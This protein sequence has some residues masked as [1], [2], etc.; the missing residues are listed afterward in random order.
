MSYTVGPFPPGSTRA[1]ILKICR[2]WDWNAKPVQPKARSADGKGVLWQ[3]LAATAPDSEVY[4]LDHG[5]V[6]VTLDPPKKQQGP[7]QPKDLQAS[8]KT[9]AAL[10]T[11]ATA[12]NPDEDPWAHY[13]PWTTPPK[14]AKTNARPSA[15]KMDLE[16]LEQRLDQKLLS[17]QTRT[18]GDTTMTVEDERIN[19]LELRMQ[20]L[21]NNVQQHHQAY[22]TQHNEVQHQL[23]QVQTQ[24]A[25][26]GAT[27]NHLLDQRFTQQLT[28]IERIMAKRPKTNE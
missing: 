10:S 3:L 25:E 15:T 28:E 23:Q 17:H 16:A 9:L 13:D 14:A 4:Q 11:K 12:S 6:L 1:A 20:R 8:A 21:E 24:V 27:F 2:A 22:L 26:Q 5:D 19:H 7:P 18:D